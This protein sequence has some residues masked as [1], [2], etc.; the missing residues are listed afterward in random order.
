MTKKRNEANGRDSAQVSPGMPFVGRFI[1]MVLEGKNLVTDIV[2]E[3]V[4]WPLSKNMNPCV[5]FTCTKRN[6]S[7]LFRFLN[8]ALRAESQ[9]AGKKVGRIARAVRS[10]P[11][12]PRRGSRG[13]RYFLSLCITSVVV[14]PG[15]TTPDEKGAQ[16]LEIFKHHMVFS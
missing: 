10:F 16:I 2:Q 13:G 14:N 4:N 8:T 11:S 9:K 7:P 6:A 12:L 15:F 1:V 3:W 5:R